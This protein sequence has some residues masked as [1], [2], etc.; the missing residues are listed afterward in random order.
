MKFEKYITPNTCDGCN[1]QFYG[2]RYNYANNLKLCNVCDHVYDRIKLPDHISY[3]QKYYYKELKLKK[4][5]KEFEFKL[6][7]IR[8]EWGTRKKLIKNERYI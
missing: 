3:K 1:K 7:K 8:D 2:N 4:L 5:N 6:N